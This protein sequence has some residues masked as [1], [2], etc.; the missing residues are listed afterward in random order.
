MAGP[1]FRD[2]ATCMPGVMSARKGG[3]PGACGMK[4]MVGPFA[5]TTTRSSV[6][7]GAEAFAGGR[8][9]SSIVL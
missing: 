9:L 8:S 5:V 6:S 2:D 1:V 3:K 4:F 7:A